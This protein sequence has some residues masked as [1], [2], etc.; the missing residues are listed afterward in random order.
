MSL[1][2]YMDK[3]NMAYAY[4]NQKKNEMTFYNMAKYWKHLK[5]KKSDTK[6]HI[7]P[8]TCNIQNRQTQR[9]KSEYNGCQRVGK[10]ENRSDY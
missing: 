5:W 4:N 6:C 8:F 3:Q 1:S 9:Q 10:G 7:Y 2:W